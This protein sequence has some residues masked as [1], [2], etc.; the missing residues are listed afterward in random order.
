MVR[1]YKDPKG[2]AL[3]THVTKE[4]G[5]TGVSG[6]GATVDEQKIVALNRRVRDLEGQV[7][8]FQ[9]SK[10]LRRGRKKCLSEMFG[11]HAFECISC[12]QSKLFDKS[13]LQLWYKSPGGIRAEGMV[14]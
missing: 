9:V 2:E 14:T 13:S 12:A 1:L 4:A 8:S 7:N 10:A 3:F 5:C 6:I 11:C